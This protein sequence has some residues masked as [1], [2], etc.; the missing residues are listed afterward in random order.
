MAGTGRGGNTG[1][2]DDAAELGVGVG[3]CM[4]DVGW[5]WVCLRREQR[6]C[7]EEPWGLGG[8]EVAQKSWGRWGDEENEERDGGPWYPLVKGDPRKGQM[9][10][11]RVCRAS[12]RAAAARR[13]LEDLGGAR[14]WGGS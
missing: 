11:A 1:I 6:W 3:V 9:G 2:R 10:G 8:R 5:G 12:E 4:V 13:G 14:L 7:G